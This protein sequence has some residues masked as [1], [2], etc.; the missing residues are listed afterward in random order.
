MEF[1]VRLIADDTTNVQGFEHLACGV[2][3]LF[4]S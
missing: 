4:L 1:N 2:N 3:I